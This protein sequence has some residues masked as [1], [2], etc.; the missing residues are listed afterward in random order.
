MNTAEHTAGALLQSPALEL[1]LV[2]R[3][4]SVMPWVSP[5]SREELSQ[6][7]NGVRTLVTANRYLALQLAEAREELERLR[8]AKAAA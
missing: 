6:V 1:T 8:G 2:Q 5:E 7:Q 4:S 3:I